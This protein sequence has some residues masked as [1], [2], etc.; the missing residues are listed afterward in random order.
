MLTAKKI[1]DRL[2]TLCKD[3]ITKLVLAELINI[4]VDPVDVQPELWCIRA[5]SGLPYHATVLGLLGALAQDRI[6]LAASYG[7]IDDD[8]DKPVTLKRFDFSP[9]PGTTIMIDDDQPITAEDLVEVLN[10]ICKD[11]ES[12]RIIAE[13][14]ERRITIKEAPDDSFVIVGADASMLGLLGVLHA[15]P[16]ERWPRVAARYSDDVGTPDTFEAFE[17]MQKPATVKEAGDLLASGKL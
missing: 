8:A 12:K 3:S 4:R 7:F 10:N 2:N 14:M 16:D 6:M 13:L 1:A 5:N 15:L 9:A 17:V 11:T